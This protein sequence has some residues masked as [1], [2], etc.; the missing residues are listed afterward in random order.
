MSFDSKNSEFMEKIKKHFSSFRKFNLNFNYLA[1]MLQIE[2]FFKIRIRHIPLT[3][4][5]FILTKI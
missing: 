5:V 2:E 4:F 1:R 3:H